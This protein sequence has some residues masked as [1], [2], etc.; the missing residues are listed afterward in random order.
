M[1]TNTTNY[2]LVKPD[3]N[4]YIDIGVINGNMDIIDTQLKNIDT[5]KASVNH[6]HDDKYYT[7]TEIDSKLGTVDEQISTLVGGK[8]EKVH[9]HDDRYYTESEVNN[10]LSAKQNNLGF[11]PVQ[12][13]GGTG[14]GTN[15]VYI[16]W[17]GSRVKIQ[18]DNSDMGN[19]VFDEH[20]PK[21]LPANGG[22]ADTVDGHHVDLGTNNTYGLR[23]I[24]MGNFDLV[25]GSTAM[26]N[27]YMYV[28]YE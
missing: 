5:N 9:T 6:N 15:K 14:Q 4:D 25:A 22:N 23:P 13:G 16:G 21:S 8:A 3:S 27:G 17:S 12:Q 28:Y 18:V 7:E 10:L 1:A 26:T 2:N 11:V 19:V 24:A 20:L